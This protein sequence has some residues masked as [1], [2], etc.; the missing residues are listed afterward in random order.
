MRIRLDVP[1]FPSNKLSRLEFD[2]VIVSIEKYQTA[3]P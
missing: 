2:Y 3:K 1:L